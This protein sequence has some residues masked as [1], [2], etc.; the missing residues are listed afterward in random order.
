MSVFSLLSGRLLAGLR[1]YNL[2]NMMTSAPVQVQ[3]P[4][5]KSRQNVK[6]N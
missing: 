4:G 5:D 2:S 3:L 6:R 1:M